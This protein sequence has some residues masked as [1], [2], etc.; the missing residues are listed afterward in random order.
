VRT[1]MTAR[2]GK[3]AAVVLALAALAA[4]VYDD[5]WVG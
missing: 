3:L 4:V 2:L 5:P 1:A